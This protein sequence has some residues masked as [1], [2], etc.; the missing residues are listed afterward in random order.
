MLDNFPSYLNNQGENFSSIFEE[1]SQ[2]TVQRELNII[3][4]NYNTICPATTLYVI[5]VAKLLLKNLC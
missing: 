4:S 1:L 3:V 5:A 2:C